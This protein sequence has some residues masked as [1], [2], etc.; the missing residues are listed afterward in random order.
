[1]SIIDNSISQ[2]MEA[3]AGTQNPQNTN[4]TSSNEFENLLGDVSSEFL[5]STLFSSNQFNISDLIQ[6]SQEQEVSSEENNL[7][8]MQLEEQRDSNIQ[9]SANIMRAFLNS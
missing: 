2:A 6:I 8:T 1:M 7:K 4:K 5:T 3:I 9:N